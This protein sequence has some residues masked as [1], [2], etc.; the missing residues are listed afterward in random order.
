MIPYSQLALRG[1][2]LGLSIG[3]YDFEKLAPQ[4]IE[5]DLWIRDEKLPL[6]CKSDQLADT[7][8]Y[9]QLVQEIRKLATEKHFELL[10]HF[11]YTLYGFIK[12]KT[13]KP[14]VIRVRKFPRPELLKQGVSFTMGD[15][16]LGDL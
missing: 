13:L 7:L 5:I 6:G 12:E 15:W 9:D 16:D 14:I 1:I 10:E 3:C 11:T 2:R 8:C 4:D